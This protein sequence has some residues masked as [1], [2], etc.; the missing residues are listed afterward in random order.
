MPFQKDKRWQIAPPAPGESLKALGA[1]P[2]LIAQLLFNRGL[3][4]R[5][6]AEAFLTGDQHLLQDPFLLPDMPQ[7]VHRLRQA[8]SAGETI[9]IFG[10]FDVD[11]VSATALLARALSRWG[12]QVVPYLPHRVTE[13][14]GLNPQAI[15]HLEDLGVTLLITVDCGVTS[16]H[17]VALA[18][19]LGMD[20]IITDHHAVPQDLP[21]AHA[22]VNPGAAGSRY[23][24][25]HLTGV[26][27]ALKL[28]QALFQEE[29]PHWSEELLELAA[30]GTVTDV[31][32]LL[33]ENRYIVQEGLRQLKTTRSPG[34]QELYRQAGIQPGSIDTQTIGWVIGPRLNAAGRLEHAITS[35]RLLTATQVEEA[36]RLALT[37][38]EYNTQR[39]V[40]TKRSLA[41]AHRQI[42]ASEELDPLIMVGGPEFSPGIIGLVAGKLAEELYRPVIALSYDEGTVTGSC[43][44]IPEFNLV[45]ALAPCADLFIRFGGHP[46]AAGFTLAAEKLPELHQ[47]LLTFANQRLGHLDL[48]PVIQVD[49]QLP[50]GHLRGDAL[51]LLR[52]L[53]PCG[54][55]NPTP[56]FLTQNVEV[57]EVRPMGSAGQHLRLKLRDGSATWEAVAFDQQWEPGLGRADIVYTMG[58]DTRRAD[59]LLR[60]NLLDYRPPS[61]Q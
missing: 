4:T 17:E 37:L 54:E 7:A 30:L 33:G 61:K 10:D 31:A 52:S 51:R 14:H 48:H 46:R 35:Y 21:P 41:L 6:E 47:R 44:T 60:L 55:G 12:A 28:A 34:L 9:G 5:G 43:R 20:T 38:E 36:Q 22:V 29:D 39:Q 59:P 40:L 13:G 57:L 2:P 8:V 1:L 26:G 3:R 53:E 32:P 18:T 23:P 50:L 11:G 24:F 16:S 58:V 19:T 56:V 25:P 15:R 45:E 42:P 27:M 49:A